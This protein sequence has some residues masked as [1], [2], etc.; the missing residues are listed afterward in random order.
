[1]KAGSGRGHGIHSPFVYTF[2]TK[3]MNDKT[4]YP[5][6]GKAEELRKQLLADKRVLTIEDMGAGS[7]VTGSDRRTVAAIARYAAKSKKIGQLLF[8]MIRY[9]Q[10][11]HIIEL[12]TS[13]G[14]TTSYLA[15]ARPTSSLITMEGA[16][17]VAG[18]ARANFVRL[19]LQ[20]V[21]LEEGNFDNTLPRV[22]AG[23]ATVDFVFIDGNHRQEPTERYFQ[24]LLKKCSNDT[25]LVFDDIHWSRE[26]EAA[27]ETIKGNPSVR[28]T[29]DLFFIGIVL[30]RQE[31][32]EKQH[33]TIRF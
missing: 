28:C 8:R 14:I 4:V 30:F 19:Q 24:W 1:M 23:T 26:M 21:L 32:H 15:L 22:L 29:I 10:P 16:A 9:Y 12:G 13:L 25:I 3:V 5:E 11:Q 33:F 2:L 7:S 18:V 31:F 6:Y 20:N 27:W 17:E